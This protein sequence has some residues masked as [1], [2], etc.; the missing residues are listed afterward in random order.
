M[1]SEL[2]L[3]Y[4]ERNPP[5]FFADSF[6][7]LDLFKVDCKAEK[8]TQGSQL[9]ILMMDISLEILVYY[10]PLTSST[11]EE[12]FLP[13]NWQVAITI[14]N[15]Y[16]LQT[17]NADNYTYILQWI[18]NSLWHRSNNLCKKV[19]CSQGQESQL[20]EIFEFLFMK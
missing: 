15:F 8:L 14:Y 9:V 1:Q 5:S 2:R 16:R 11:S 20:W 19:L 7:T 4:A 12:R 13:M 17:T 3:S 18:I 6:D 10:E